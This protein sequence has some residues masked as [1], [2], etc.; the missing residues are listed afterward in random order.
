MHNQQDYKVQEQWLYW[1]FTRY[2]ID[3]KMNSSFLFFMAE[4][5]YISYYFLIVEQTTSFPD[6]EEKYKTIV[7][8][9]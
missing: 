9:I 6:L 2:I 3:C 4:G 5:S 8:L 1:S 7:N